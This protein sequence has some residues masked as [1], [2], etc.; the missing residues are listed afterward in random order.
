VRGLSNVL[1]RDYQ[2]KR[3]MGFPPQSFCQIRRLLP[4]A[5]PEK[6][7]LLVQGMTGSPGNYRIN[8]N[9]GLRG[10]FAPGLYHNQTENSW[11]K[12]NKFNAPENQSCNPQIKKHPESA[13]SSVTHTYYLIS[14][15]S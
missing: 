1:E 3:A 12:K 8:T 11:A 5:G 13:L 10:N 2:L 7:G 15:Q 14:S 9:V 6:T 4:R